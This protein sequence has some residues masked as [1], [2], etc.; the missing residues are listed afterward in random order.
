V[1]FRRAP[2]SEEVRKAYFK[3][4]SNQADLLLNRNFTMEAEQTLR[5]A[6]Q[7]AP[8]SSEAVFGY[9]NLLSGQN[10]IAEAIPVI[11]NAIRADP[12]KVEFRTLLEEAKRQ[13]K[14]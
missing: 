10:R 12:K 4:A 2:L 7:I 6:A 9:A 11:E 5:L 14:R 1:S 13:A 3:L 8:Y